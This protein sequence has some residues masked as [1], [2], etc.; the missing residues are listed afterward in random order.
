[1][2]IVICYRVCIAGQL[3]R[4]EVQWKAPVHS[5]S[6]QG[7]WA[8]F[9]H[10]HTQ[11][12]PNF[13]HFF[14]SIL[15]INMKFFHLKEITW[16]YT[17][18]FFASFQQGWSCEMEGGGDVISFLWSLRCWYTAVAFPPLGGAATGHGRWGG[19]GWYIFS[20]VFKALVHC[21]SFSTT[22]GAAIS[23]LWSLQGRYTA[24]VFPPIGGA[25]TGR[26]RWGGCYIFS[27]VSMA[28]VHC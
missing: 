1:M 14:F 3:T 24:V 22:R 7:V 21:C 9:G 10:P 27:M 17:R 20:M 15:S 16:H 4:E 25:A 11:T 2:V 13:Q 28:L 26:G 18:I 19:G 5:F 23:F 6:Q 12:A 8:P